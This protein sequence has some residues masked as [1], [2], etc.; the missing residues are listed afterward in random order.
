[1][2]NPSKMLTMQNKAIRTS[3]VAILATITLLI[4]SL[5]AGMNGASAQNNSSSADRAA[6][7][8]GASVNLQPNNE[9]SNRVSVDPESPYAQDAK[10]R[11]LP[12]K[13][14]YNELYTAIA[15][16]ALL[17]AAVGAVY[18]VKKRKR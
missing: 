15:I 7:E 2:T 16:C 12:Q 1:M 3:L 17:A 10:N 11:G 9:L 14:N 4:V 8:S 13:P 6:P 5:V 18:V